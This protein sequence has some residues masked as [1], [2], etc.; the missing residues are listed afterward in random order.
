MSSSIVA[1]SSDNVS[2]L[3]SS[4]ANVGS[5]ASALS[6]QIVVALEIENCSDCTSVASWLGGLAI[7]PRI[8]DGL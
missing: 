1:T 3:G 7:R 8:G 5:L 6:G 4:G 2:V